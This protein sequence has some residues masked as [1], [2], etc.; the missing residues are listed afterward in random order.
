M[1]NEF[2]LNKKYNWE[3]AHNPI[4]KKYVADLYQDGT[5][6]AP[7]ATELFNNTGLYFTYDYVAPGVYVVICNKDIFTSPYA[8]KYQVSISNGTYVD[9][10]TAPTGYSIIAGPGFT[11]IIFITSSDLTAPADG[12]IGNG[13]QNTLELTIY[14]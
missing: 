8:Q 6:T 4:V 14:P 7:I 9:D 2:N 12:I 13:V 10:A 3:T 11:N 1:M 5:A